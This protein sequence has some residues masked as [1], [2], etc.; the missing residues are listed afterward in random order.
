MKGREITVLK[1][2]SSTDGPD[3]FSCCHFLCAP[4][5]QQSDVKQTDNKKAIRIR[6]AKTGG[7]QED[8]HNSYRKPFL[9][10]TPEKNSR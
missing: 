1:Q 6:S 8:K 10:E 5:E 3:G 7:Y 9:Q 2:S 4:E